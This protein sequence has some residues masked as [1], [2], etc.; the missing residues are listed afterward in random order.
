MKKYFTITVLALFFC[1][2]FINIAAANELSKDEK[3]LKLL[4]FWRDETN[5]KEAYKANV[6]DCSNMASLLT[7]IFSDY[8]TRILLGYCED[9][10]GKR[11]GHTIVRILINGEIWYIDPPTLEVNTKEA[12]NYWDLV[13]FKNYKKAIYYMDAWYG[14]GKGE[15]EYDI[16][17]S[18]VMENVFRKGDTDVSKRS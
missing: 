14:T 11:T 1:A 16:P 18:Y 12:Y 3:A 15:K 2:S 17:W 10:D 5:W 6:F 9:G 13:E 7:L 4:S 8:Q